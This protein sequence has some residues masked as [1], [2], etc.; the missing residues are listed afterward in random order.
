MLKR[1]HLA[2][3][4]AAVL[5]AAG[6][7]AAQGIGGP[8]F[9]RS[10][11][12]QPTMMK[13]GRMAAMHEAMQAQRSSQPTYDGWLFV[14]GEA[15]WVRAPQA[16]TAAPDARIAAP[17]IQPYGEVSADGWKFVGGETGWVRAQHSYELQGGKLVHAH[18]PWCVASHDLPAQAKSPLPGQEQQWNLYPGA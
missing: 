16:T 5:M 7:A 6:A 9:K 3:I 14:G 4:G 8:G 13:Q 12:A 2:A 10:D 15:G 1:F 17:A 11:A 18:E